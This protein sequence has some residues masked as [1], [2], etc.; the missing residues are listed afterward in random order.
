MPRNPGVTD[1]QIIRMY[2]SK[3]PF[4]KMKAVTGLSDRG[5]R[6]VIHKH[7]VQMNRE[8]YSGQPRKHQVNEDF[9]KT[10][11]HEMAWVLGLFVTDGHV[12]KQTHSIVFSQKDEQILRL[13][14]KH[15]EAD[16]VLAS[17][18]PT[19]L[20]P[21]LIINSKKIK[22]DL[23]SLGIHPNKSMTVPFP[24]VPAQYL[25]SFIEGVIEGDGWVQRKGYVMNVTTASFHFANGLL[26]TFQSW[27]LRSEIT[28]TKNQKGNSI[29]RV[30]VKGKYDLPKLA[31]I[32]YNDATM[33]YSSY[34]KKYMS[35]RLNEL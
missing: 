19:R 1:E 34:K 3:M 4:K 7:G 22:N 9:F 16:Y 2:K 14:A 6:N 17:T 20:T 8:Q 5:I 24:E 30:W 18:G 10:W 31:K 27:E 32:I 28:S 23:E 21:S 26:S 29:Y 25:P 12:N 11:T 35:Q 13:I 15:M 33:E